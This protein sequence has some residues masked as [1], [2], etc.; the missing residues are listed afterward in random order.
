M[1]NTLKNA[2]QV[3]KVIFAIST[4]PRI[5]VWLYFIIPELYRQFTAEIEGS[6]E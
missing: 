4:S 1:R 3:V 6:G 2:R 5:V